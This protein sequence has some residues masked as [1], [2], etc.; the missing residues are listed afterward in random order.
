MQEVKKSIKQAYNIEQDYLMT[1]VKNPCLM[2]DLFVSVGG[3]SAFSKEAKLIIDIMR[4][5]NNHNQLSLDA[6]QAR[7]K[8]G[9]AKLFLYHKLLMQSILVFLKIEKESL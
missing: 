2:E 1:M 5:L 4:E 8:A 7:T 3:S 6:L 9:L